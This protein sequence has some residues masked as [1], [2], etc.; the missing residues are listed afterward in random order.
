MSRTIISHDLASARFRAR[1]G[2][3]E[4]QG[5]YFVEHAGETALELEDCTT[6]ME[7]FLR[8]G[9]GQVMSDHLTTDLKNHYRATP[10]SKLD[11]ATKDVKASKKAQEKRQLQILIDAANE[12]KRLEDAQEEA[13]NKALKEEEVR[14]LRTKRWVWSN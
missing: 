8:E 12:A 6:Q 2:K 3:T 9:Q 13:Q 11:E 4:G 5:R 7:H 14:I 10:R 1:S